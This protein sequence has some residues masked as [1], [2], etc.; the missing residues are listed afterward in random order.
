MN[1]TISKQWLQYAANQISQNQITLAEAANQAHYETQIGIFI[2]PT[3]V[4]ALK[5]Q[6]SINNISYVSYSGRREAE[7]PKEF[8]NIILTYQRYLNCGE[9]VTY[10]TLLLHYPNIKFNYV[11][12]IFEKYK[13]YKFRLV[14]NTEKP[15][16]RYE[17][18]YVNQIWHADIHY[19]QKAGMPDLMY[20][21][22]IIDDRS[23]FIVG[24]DLL[25]KKTQNACKEVL[26][27]AIQT[28][29]PP[30]IMWTDN[31]GENK[32]QNMLQFLK[33]N[34]IYPAFIKPGNPQQNG[35]IERFWQ[36]LE[37][38]TTCPNDIHQFIYQYNNIRASM[39]LKCDN[40]CLRPCDV[41]FD[42]NM[43]WKRGYEWKWVVDG[44]ETD[45]PYDPQK[46]IEYFD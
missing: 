27:R 29:G 44:K 41:F 10:Y 36:K 22:C 3:S 4:S 26:N 19:F 9:K 30:C 42:P 46:K 28:Y 39:A 6:F 7:V 38:N 18:I 5:Y 37:D 25:P 21:Y 12:K 20:L 8:E 23:R 31:G 34:R 40:K 2:K 24:Y 35:K 32:G 11:R 1:H 15:R 33:E 45:F 43:R 17:A 14:Q 13:L 16:C